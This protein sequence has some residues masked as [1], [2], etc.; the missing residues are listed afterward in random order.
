MN[1]AR[2]PR[3]LSILVLGIA[4]LSPGLA[5]A[6]DGS[7][8]SRGLSQSQANALYVS[9]QQRPG[10]E[11]C[12]DMFPDKT[13]ITLSFVSETSKPFALCSNSFAVLYSGLHKAPIVVV[14]RLN[15]SQM[16]DAQGEK[17]SN[18]FYAD[19]RLP[20]GM[21]AELSDFRGS[22]LD[23]GHMSPAANQ[24]DEISMAQSF[25]LSN[26]VL[27]NPANNR[28]P[29]AAAESA[30]RKYALRAAGNVFVFS[31]PLFRPGYKTVGSNQVWEPTH[32]FKLVYDA[33]D[34][35]AWAYLL[36]NNAE[37]RIGPPMDYA[38]FVKQTGLQFLAGQRVEGSVAGRRAR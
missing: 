32:L 25:A 34:H 18:Q 11:S 22:G 2:F 14:E 24:P 35:R 6:R 28:K 37:S 8:R 5:D 4:L 36:A 30:T 20:R 33:T 31:G 17:R 29:W 16:L 13:P 27:Q 38:E 21:R 9:G 3:L 12:R 15:K 19:P 7:T 26:M 1:Q 23:R 10:F